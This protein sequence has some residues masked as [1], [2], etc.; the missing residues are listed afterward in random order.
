M[1]R[2]DYPLAG[3]TFADEHGGTIRVVGRLLSFRY[4]V[5]YNDGSLRELSAQTIEQLYPRPLQV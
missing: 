1:T 2:P 5:E 3:R 4:V